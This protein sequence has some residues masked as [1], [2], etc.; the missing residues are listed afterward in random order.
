MFYPIKNTQGSNIPGPQLRSLDGQCLDKFLR[1]REASQ[2]WSQYGPVYR[3]WSG[4]VPEVV[5]TR[6]EDVKAFHSDSFTHRKSKSS[7]GG[8]LFHELLGDCMGLINGERWKQVRSHFEPQFTHRTVAS[9]S[10]Y[11]ELAAAGYLQ[12]FD[13]KR[14]E[15]LQLHAASEFSRFPFMTTAEY[16]YG[17]LTKDQKAELWRL[18]QES[19]SLMGNVISGGVYRFRLCQWARPQS[20]RRLRR[21]QTE[22]R[23]FNEKIM[24]FPGLMNNNLPPAFEAWNGVKNG[25]IST[26][27]VASFI[28][29]CLHSF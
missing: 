27:E 29:V 1:G 18:G 5:I 2:E 24:K 17:P 10:R 12:G 11:S 8:W 6:P 22:W 23:I 21:F 20:F 25:R 28:L 13:T 9:I 16:L 7:N 26:D 14:A 4:F 15:P 19:L 3:I